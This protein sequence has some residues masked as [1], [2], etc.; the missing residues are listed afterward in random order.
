MSVFGSNPHYGGMNAWGPKIPLPPQVARAIGRDH[1]RLKVLPGSK[2]V[3]AALPSSRIP[4]PFVAEMARSARMATTTDPR[5]QA[6]PRFATYRFDVG[7]APRHSGAAYGVAAP[8]GSPDLTGFG[9]YNF[10]MGLRGKT[11]WEVRGGV[12]PFAGPTSGGNTAPPSNTSVSVPPTP[13]SPVVPTSAPVPGSQTVVTPASVPAS[14]TVIPTSTPVIPSSVSVT[15]PPAP[16]PP[17]VFPPGTSPA[18]PWTTPPGPQSPWPQQTPPASPSAPST[19]DGWNWP[20][21]A[22]SSYPQ[23][24]PG[25]VDRAIDAGFGKPVPRSIIGPTPSPGSSEPARPLFPDSDT[26]P[27]DFFVPRK[28]LGTGSADE[29]REARRQKEADKR[30]AARAQADSSTEEEFGQMSLLEPGVFTPQKHKR[31]RSAPPASR[32]KGMPPG[33]VQEP[34]F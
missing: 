20:N 26:S 16:I 5:W 24:G 8:T 28:R 21:G 29:K 2:P 18:G 17:M 10:D 32:R 14:G 31:L 12:S 19:P 7:A 6:N 27:A 4:V 11:T 3:L 1:I 15:S 22:I 13:P 23:A 33:Y 25:M 30:S 9:Q 34:L